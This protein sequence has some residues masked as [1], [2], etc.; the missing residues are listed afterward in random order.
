MVV[1]T[2]GVPGVSGGGGY[3]SIPHSA[4]DS[5]SQGMPDLDVSSTRQEDPCITVTAPPTHTHRIP[6]TLAHSWPLHLSFPFSLLWVGFLR[7][8]FGLVWLSV[9]SRNIYSALACG[10]TFPGLSWQV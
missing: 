9:L 5:P 4:Q 7:G 8:L 6:V 2:G 1:T 10:G 3:C